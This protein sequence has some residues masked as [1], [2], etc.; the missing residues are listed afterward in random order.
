MC[1][2]SFFGDEF[3]KSFSAP[4]K[5]ARGEKIAALSEDELVEKL[6]KNAL[7]LKD[8]PIEKRTY[9]VCHAALVGI[10]A[11]G[12]SDTGVLSEI[13]GNVLDE[14]L[15]LEAV[16]LGRVSLKNISKNLLTD[17]I[18]KVIAIQYSLKHVPSEKRTYDICV[19]ALNYKVYNFEFVPIELLEGDKGKSLLLLAIEKGSSLGL[20]PLGFLNPLPVFTYEYEFYRELVKINGMELTYVPI[21]FKIKE[22]CEIALGNNVW[23]IEFIPAEVLTLEMCISA[24]KKSNVFE[25]IPEKFRTDL[26]YTIAISNDFM[27]LEDVPI[28]FITKEICEIALKNSALEIKFIPKEV[29]TLEM[30][31]SAIRERDVFQYIPEKFR[32]NTFYEMTFARN[33]IK[34]EDI[35]KEKINFELLKNLIKINYNCFEK[36]SDDFKTEELYLI[37]IEQNPALIESI[38]DDKIKEK[39][40]QWLL[41]LKNAK[42]DAH[43][44]KITEA[45]NAFY[46]EYLKTSPKEEKEIKKAQA[47]FYKAFH[48]LDEREMYHMYID[49][50]RAQEGPL[51]FENEPGYALAMELAFF[52]ISLTLGKQLDID[53]FIKIHDYCVQD[54]R[55]KSKNGGRPFL[56]GIAY[57]STSYGIP[58]Q[59]REKYM[60]AFKELSDEKILWSFPEFV[61][62]VHSRP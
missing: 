61:E 37:A 28:K 35:P 32:N 8:V 7:W 13:P 22:M 4:R 25:H 12:S 26:I 6:Q 36:I 5:Q 33:E 41:T 2:L 14:N 48:E 29:L 57:M 50:D 18:C 19:A 45:K 1:G 52:Y 58:C 10:N 17:P 24:I 23:A 39:C 27:T 43:W 38:K 9:R 62:N 15:I 51:A 30:C 16:S 3:M 20:A 56:T 40:T 53:E 34:F 55:H 49:F 44:E 21:Q 60:S 54:V 11:A 47:V 42:L 59:E 46:A 31:V